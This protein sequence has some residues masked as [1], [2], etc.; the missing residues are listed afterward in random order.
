MSDEEQQPEREERDGAVRGRPGRRSVPQLEARGFVDRPVGLEHGPAL[1]VAI[2]DHRHRVEEHRPADEAE[3]PL[4]LLQGLQALASKPSGQ[5]EAP[6]WKGP[7][8]DRMPK[9]P[10]NRPYQYQQ[11]GQHGEIDVYSLGA[12]G[13]PGG[14]GEAADIGNWGD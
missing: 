10:W 5:P 3:R 12:D 9:D 6:N 1:A 13:R 14:D 8:L 7:Y 4:E 2:E 11:P